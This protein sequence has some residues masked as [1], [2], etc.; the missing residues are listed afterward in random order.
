MVDETYG[1]STCSTLVALVKVK[2][3]WSL[4]N[5]H[6]VASGCELRFS[7]LRW[8]QLSWVCSWIFLA[9]LHR[10]ANGGELRFRFSVDGSSG[11]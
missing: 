4:A 11:G 2:S 1:L 7:L 9:C 8:W 5:F 3:T 10:V 6:R